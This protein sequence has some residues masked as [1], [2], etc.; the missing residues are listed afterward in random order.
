MACTLAAAKPIVTIKYWEAVSLAVEQSRALP[1]IESF[2]PTLK[3]EFLKASSRLFL[4]NEQRRTL[5]KGLSFVHFC[6]KQYFTYSS[7]I[8]AAGNQF[9]PSVTR[10]IQCIKKR[11]RFRWKI[12]RVSHKQAPHPSRSHCEKCHR[13]AT[14]GQR[15]VAIYSSNRDRLSSHL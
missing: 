4:P 2:L 8:T 3:E 13:R 12:V 6:G 11:K 1:D 9:T 15:V 14:A 7:L 5:F 10:K